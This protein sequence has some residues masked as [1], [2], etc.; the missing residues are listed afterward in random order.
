[1]PA[2]RSPRLCRGIFFKEG[3]G[4]GAEKCRAA[5]TA[6]LW[7]RYN[8][9]G[10]LEPRFYQKKKGAGRVMQIGL[11]QFYVGD[12]KGKTTA[13]VGQLARAH[14]AGLRCMMVQF[15]KNTPSG[16]REALA[17]LGIPVE[18]ADTSNQKFV[19]EM[20]ASEKGAYLTAQRALYTKAVRAIH[21]GEY[22]VV[23]LD[24]I[25]D[26]LA[27]GGLDL[28]ALRMALLSRP[29]GVEVLLSGREM[30]RKLYDIAGYVT[31][32]QSVKH[33]YAGGQAARRGIEY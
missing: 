33:P 32:M 8:E 11:L 2:P 18:L 22:D 5:L 26:L 1:M 16:E 20:S 12:G 27:L 15:L 30:P 19:Y 13:M 7:G 23:A 25:L 29:Q 31:N 6:A 17:S 21:S 14:G 3:M 10:G 4:K 24:E 9:S 28:D